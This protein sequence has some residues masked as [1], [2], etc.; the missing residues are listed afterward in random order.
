M[1]KCLLMGLSVQPTPPPCPAIIV[2]TPNSIPL[3]VFHQCTS[4]SCFGFVPPPSTELN[5]QALNNPYYAAWIQESNSQLSQLW[6]CS[7]SRQ[8]S[9]LDIR[10]QEPFWSLYGNSYAPP[11]IPRTAPMGAMELGNPSAHHF[12]VS[13]ADSSPSDPQFIPRAA[14]TGIMEAQIDPTLLS[15]S[16]SSYALPKPQTQSH[17]ANDVASN[18]NG[19]SS[20]LESDSDGE[21][22]RSTGDNTSGHDGG[23]DS[24]GAINQQVTTH[25]GMFPKLS[26]F[27]LNVFLGFSQESQPSNLVQHISLSPGEDF[28]YSHD[29][30]NNAAQWA[31]RE[32]NNEQ[33]Q[34]VSVS[35]NIY[36]RSQAVLQLTAHGNVADILDS[37]HWINGRPSAPHPDRLVAVSSNIINQV[38][39]NAAETN[40]CPLN[41]VQ[42]NVTITVSH[43]CHTW[44]SKKSKYDSVSLEMLAYYLPVW[45]DL[46]E[47]AKWGCWVTHVIIRKSLR[48]WYT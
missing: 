7:L 30:G 19:T 17:D 32:S 29:E 48:C 18:T 36:C 3:P 45:K 15:Q 44:N 8:P 42:L 39:L 22:S 21:K 11:F 20:N 16:N 24:W 5:L 28:N 34:L 38:Q 41:N 9:M 14:S 13:T 27:N 46:L 43:P 6:S 31:L 1:P 37:H 33:S 23:I 2:E 40:S 47:D 35:I 4:D 10:E 26:E 25:P 12:T